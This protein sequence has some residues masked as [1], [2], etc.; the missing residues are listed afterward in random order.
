MSNY[1]YLL[2]K[3]SAICS[4]LLHLTFTTAVS[5]LLLASHA[6]SMAEDSASIE[7]GEIKLFRADGQTPGRIITMVNEH[8][9][10]AGLLTAG[11][12]ILQTFNST[13]E[14]ADYIARM[15]LHFRRFFKVVDLNGKTLMPGFVEPHV[16]LPLMVNFSAGADLSTCLP[17]PYHYRLYGDDTMMVDGREVSTC[18]DFPNFKDDQGNYFTSDGWQAENPHLTV[19]DWTMTVLNESESRLIGG[20]NGKTEWIVGNGI[21]P[22]RFGVT[23]E[24]IEM[25]QA[26]RQNPAVSIEENVK[27]AGPGE[28]PVFLLDQSGHV[29]YVNGQAFIASGICERWP[30]GPD[31]AKKDPPVL[32][33]WAVGDDGNY[34]GLLQEEDAYALFL[35]AIQEAVGADESSP[36][37]FM[38]K[39]DG[40][41]ATGKIVQRIAEKGVTTLIDAGG[42]S[43]PMIQ[44]LGAVAVGSEKVGYEGNMKAAPFRIRTLVASNVNHSN[45]EEAAKIAE[46]LYTGPWPEKVTINGKTIDNELGTFGVNGIKFWIDGSTQGCSAF[47]VDSYASNGIC[48]EAGEGVH[49]SHGANYIVFANAAHDGTQHP[50]NNA[51]ALTASIYTGPDSDEGVAFYNA[52]KPFVEKGMQI[53]VHAN[54][55][56]AMIGAARTAQ[57]LVEDCHW[58]FDDGSLPM[59][60]H[61]AT[62][63]GGFAQSY[64]RT[65]V[66]ELLS[67]IRGETRDVECDG[68]KVAQKYDIG[69]SH[70]SGHVAYWG[71]GFLSL[72][73]G[74]VNFTALGTDSDE[75]GRAPWLDANKAELGG[76]KAS[77]ES[78]QNSYEPFDVSFHSDAP[79][80]PVSPLWYVSQMVTRNTWT[81]PD[82]KSDASYE[83]PS[84]G[85]NL[86]QKID[87][88]QALKGI[89]TIP[90]KQN[91]LDPYIGSLEPGKRADLVILDSDP[92]S[93]NK[94]DLPYIKVCATYLNGE[95]WKP[96]KTSEKCK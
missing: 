27:G 69:L 60:L 44:Y 19:L 8:D 63:G 72:L 73:D 14:I 91:G 82:I 40:V 86:A 29:A 76:D 57:K 53:Q 71:G 58:K 6:P 88:Y 35:K 75:E 17:E 34:T 45:S 51:A 37:Y 23:E 55:D 77:D 25:T 47:L 67:K 59:I 30:C 31:D 79:I 26:F 46:R 21:D 1:K 4:S 49:G 24:A 43:E 61:H 84:P 54:G 64:G 50:D 92:L 94:M 90:A 85:S 65:P 3:T 28:L 70:T 93:V 62:V 36:F 5:L 66:A 9:R 39:K 15:P 68:E 38:N 80:T 87:V 13:Q 74:K 41:E 42:F 18:G 96:E 78:A 52:M 32:G 33:K 48:T 12:T 2:N 89:T 95:E 10:P 16:H 56:K 83:L 7:W 22:A 11:D 20:K 81:Y